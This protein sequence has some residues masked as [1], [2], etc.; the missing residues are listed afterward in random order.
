MTDIKKIFFNRTTVICYLGGTIVYSVVAGLIDCSSTTTACSRV[1]INQRNK[2][3]QGDTK[4][5]ESD[6]S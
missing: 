5:N 6:L 4:T 2:S 1:I 3:E